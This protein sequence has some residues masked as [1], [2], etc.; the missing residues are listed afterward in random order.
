MRATIIYTGQGACAFDFNIPCCD[1]L[2][3]F[4]HLIQEGLVNGMVNDEIG[5]RLMTLGDMVLLPNGKYYMWHCYPCGFYELQNG[6]K[7]AL[8]FQFDLAAKDTIHEN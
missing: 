7:E 6:R 3:R 1:D 4:F 2:N 5:V 8:S